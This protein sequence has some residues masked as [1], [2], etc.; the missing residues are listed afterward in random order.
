MPISGAEVIAI[1]SIIGNIVAV[2]ISTIVAKEHTTTYLEKVTLYKGMI[3]SIEGFYVNLSTNDCAASKK[4][5]NDFIKNLNQAWAFASGNVLDAAYAFLE[6]VTTGGISSDEEKM[7]ALHA[8]MAAIRKDMGLR[9]PKTRFKPL[10]A[11]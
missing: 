9:F 5:K 3:E 4:M 7:R 10:N 2:Y 6:T 11:S 8:L 1:V